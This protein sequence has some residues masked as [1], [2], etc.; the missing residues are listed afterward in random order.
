M[1]GRQREIIRRQ[2]ELLSVYE[3]RLKRKTELINE[4]E[5]MKLDAEARLDN[6]QECNDLLAW[7]NKKISIEKD[8]LDDITAQLYAEWCNEG[9]VADRARELDRENERLWH[10]NVILRAAL[11]RLDPEGARAICGGK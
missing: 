2:R 11:A 3:E 7:E 1:F 10:E 6:V 8:N 4:A 9:R 5:A